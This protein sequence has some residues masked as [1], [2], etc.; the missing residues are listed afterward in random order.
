MVRANQQESRQGAYGMGA[1][2]ALGLALAVLV[3]Q[4]ATR[5]QFLIEDSFIA[6]RYARNWAE[7]GLATWNPSD[8]PPVEGYSTVLW[9][10][11]LRGAYAFGFSLPAAAQL[12]GAIFGCGTVVLLHRFLVLDLR[13]RRTAGALGIAALV[14][15]PPFVIWCS[16]GLETSA[17][18][19]FM[20]LA[21]RALLQKQSKWK[22][23]RL[24]GITAGLAT[25]AVIWLRPEGFL[26]AAGITLTMILTARL[27]PLTERPSRLRWTL[28]L[29]L[30]LLGLAL[31]LFWR[32][33]VYGTWLPNTV[34]AKSGLDGAVLTRGMASS[35]SW[36]LS[37]L[38]PLALLVLA[39]FSLRGPQ[40][41]GLLACL[42]I[43]CGGLA[44]NLLVGGDWMPYFRFLTPISPFLCAALAISLAHLPARGAWAPGLPLVLM[45]ALPLSG[46]FQYGI[47]PEALLQ[48]L[49]YRS[50]DKGT[51]R[52]ERA[53]FKRS[54]QNLESFRAIGRALGA[55]YKP[56]DSIVMGAIGAIGWESDMVVYDRNGLVDPEVASLPRSTE[57]RSAGHDRRVPR[58]WFLKRKPTVLQAMIVPKAALEPDS[59]AFDAAV[60]ASARIVFGQ[61]PQGEAPLREAVIPRVY[62]VPQQVNFPKAY[63]LL[64]WEY[65]EDT[66]RVRQFWRHY[67]Y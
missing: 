47:A 13:L 44:Y 34:A 66:Q 53:Q 14:L 26:W 12:M 43:C 42:L 5:S 63:A 59:P 32:H 35:A 3:G 4:L 30:Q 54:A 9:V 38:I 61:D 41:A 23:E 49:N 22:K 67:G 40:R 39:P 50:F 15:H 56:E 37:T 20:F 1:W 36:A 55:I 27:R 28:T 31:L 17:Q 48:R 10:W 60:R 29:G 21:A 24:Y 8:T 52:S 62:E 6:F 65:S 57:S 18:T 46:E 19:F 11:L 64:V 7:M 25:I 33:S 2:I 16:G 51:F 45:G 58:A